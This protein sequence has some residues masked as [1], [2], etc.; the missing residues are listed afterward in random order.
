MSWFKKKLGKLKRKIRRWYYKPVRAVQKRIDRANIRIKNIVFIVGHKSIAPGAKGVSGIHE[1][2][3]WKKVIKLISCPFF[4][5]HFVDREGTTI[6]G[7]IER[8][9]LYKPDLIIELHFNAFNKKAHGTTV[10]YSTP[11]AKIAEGWCTFTAKYLGR[12]NR[13]GRNVSDVI[14]GV[15][16][17]LGAQKV[18]PYSFLIEPFFGDNSRDYV[19]VK[20]MAECINAYLTKLE[21]EQK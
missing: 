21:G 7:A 10:R 8:A 18:A 4:N 16:N 15:S 9:A 14:R 2:F 11:S 6:E 3:Y 12:R 17:V 13:K 5:I 20:E 19:T 1:F